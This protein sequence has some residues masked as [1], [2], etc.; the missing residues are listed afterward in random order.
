[1]VELRGDVYRALA[2]EGGDRVV[3]L[4]TPFGGGKTHS[5]LALYHLARSRDAAAR[6]Q[7][8]D[9]VPDPGAVRVCVLSGEYLDHARGRAVD[10]RTIRTLWGELAY[11]LGGWEAY[12]A[13]L[14]DG[15]EGPPPGGERPGQLLSAAAPALV[16]LDE[17]LVY[18]AKAKAVTLGVR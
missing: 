1:M 5:L 13:L 7:E 8:L 6:V 11:Q 14:V 3:Q 9:R 16:L 18:A 4:K 12:D 10:G 2:G 15:E 17:V